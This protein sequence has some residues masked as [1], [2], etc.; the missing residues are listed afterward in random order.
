[1][2]E[3]VK[4]E[5]KRPTP[6]VVN[7]HNGIKELPYNWAGCKPGGKPHVVSVPREVF[8]YLN[9]STQAI[10]NGALSVA[11]SEPNK[12]QIHT[13]IVE[14]E[15]ALINSKTREEY[16][17]LLKG[18]I[19]KMKKELGKITSRQEKM[20]VKQIK[21]ELAETEGLHNTKIEFIDEWFTSK[22]EE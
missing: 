4:L 15:D 8:D 17:E 21:D 18:N 16:V 5:R 3:F 2:S 20:F 14:I 1:M 7:Y 13:E 11:D 10:V 22:V 12:E 9:M 6:Y 19:N